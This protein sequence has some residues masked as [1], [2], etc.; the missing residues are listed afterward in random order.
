MRHALKLIAITG[1]GLFFAPIALAGQ[2]LGFLSGHWCQNTESNTIEEI[3][4]P[5][6]AGETVG[7]SRTLKDG[8]QVSFE[9]LRIARLDGLVTYFA[10]PGGRPAVAFTRT[11]GGKEWVRFNNPQHD[12]PTRIEYR[13]K[14]STLGVTISG[15]GKNGAESSIEF[16]YEICGENQNQIEP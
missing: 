10:Q 12:F 14:G 1:L 13:R 3:W 2:P 8:K 6:S 9:F 11:E 7:M 4:L 16:V 5:P 15:P